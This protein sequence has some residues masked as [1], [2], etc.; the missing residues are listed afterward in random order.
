MLGNLVKWIK[1]L[2]KKSHP[3][4]IST[5]QDYGTSSQ[6]YMPSST[7]VVVNESWGTSQP[8]VYEKEKELPKDERIVKKPVEVVKDVIA[9][10]PKMNLID[11]KK[12]IR[13]VERRKRCL[14]E[15]C[16]VTPSDEIE[17]LK[18]LKA[19][20]KYLKYAKLFRWAITTNE[21]IAELLKTYKL[22]N[23]GFRSYFKSVPMEAIDE[24]EKFMN[25]WKKVSNTE[26]DLRL[27][28]DDGGTE[29]KKDPILLASSP[30]GKWFYVL[31]AWDKEVQYVD[32][33]VYKGK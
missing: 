23:V 29:T 9:E 31:G 4:Y 2:R 25:A 5:F 19:R 26:P 15:E 3:A 20:L 8:T 11:L 32:D 17:A 30:F 22:S 21:K 10:E 27:I 18:Y 7:S 13:L 33:I 24:L 16:K 1:G 28:I 12:Q 14:E 6:V